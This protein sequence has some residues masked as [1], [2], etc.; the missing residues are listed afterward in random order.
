MLVS[1]N[2]A[3]VLALML[4]LVIVFVLLRLYYIKTARETKRIEGLGKIVR[5][6]DNLFNFVILYKYFLLYCYTL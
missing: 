3:A 2:M 1:V 6:L 5:L 4:P